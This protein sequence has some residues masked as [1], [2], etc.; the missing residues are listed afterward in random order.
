MP[1]D[2]ESIESR[3]E[4]DKIKGSD[5]M[6]ELLDRARHDKGLELKR[7]LGREGRIGVAFTL[8]ILALPTI[9]PMPGPFGFIFGTCLAFV[10]VQMMVGANR[11]WLPE[12]IGRRVLP[13]KAVEATISATRPWVLRFEAWLSPGRLAVLT[14]RK[15]RIVLA[16]PIL[17]LAILIAL[18]IPFGNTLP[19]LAVALIAVSLAERDGLMVI[20]AMALFAVACVASY[21]LA[22]AVGSAF[23]SLI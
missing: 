17:L 19:A 14:G 2:A 5:F 4:E 21:Y 8:L 3:I 15:A 6:L 23:V 16:I 13:L 20:A 12:W 10:A 9:I 7:V 18:P 22:T 11:L 1:L